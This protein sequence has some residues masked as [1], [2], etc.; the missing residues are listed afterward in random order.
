MAYIQLYWWCLANNI[1]Y[2]RNTGFY[3]YFIYIFLLC[4]WTLLLLLLHLCLIHITLHWD[5]MHFRFACFDIYLFLFV[6]VAIP[7]DVCCCCYLYFFYFFHSFEFIINKC[8]MHFLDVKLVNY[9]MKYVVIKGK[10][11]WVYLTKRN[12]T[13]YERGLKFFLGIWYLACTLIYLNNF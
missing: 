5:W 6:I 10:C 7:M 12:V 4:S 1:V 3:L 11:L 9:I 2:W 8:K 13:L